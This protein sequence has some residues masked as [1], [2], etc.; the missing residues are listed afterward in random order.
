MTAG[1]FAHGAQL[2][3]PSGMTLLKRDISR[4]FV[5]RADLSGQ[6]E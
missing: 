4:V 3:Y 6:F 2:S 1:L 5:R